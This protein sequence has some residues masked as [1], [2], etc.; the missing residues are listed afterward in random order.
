MPDQKKLYFWWEFDFKTQFWKVH[1][2]IFSIAD[3]ND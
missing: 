2:T 3:G 1:E